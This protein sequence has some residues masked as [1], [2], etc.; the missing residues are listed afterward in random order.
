MSLYIP[1]KK[2]WD[3]FTAVG[4]EKGRMLKRSDSSAATKEEH[5]ALQIF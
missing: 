5:M 3:A 2:L 4:L 1:E